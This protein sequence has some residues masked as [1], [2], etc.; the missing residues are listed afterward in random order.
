MNKR[1]REEDSLDDIGTNT[2]PAT[3]LNR[4][5]SLAPPTFNTVRISCHGEFTIQNS[6]EITEHSKIDE[7]KG[8]PNY[9]QFHIFFRA[10]VGRCDLARKSTIVVENVH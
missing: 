10:Q 8:N 5:N 1:P 9:I 3:N 4:T 7:I 2:G 6:L